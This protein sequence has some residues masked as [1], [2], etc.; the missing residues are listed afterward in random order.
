[1]P[2]SSDLSEVLE[3]TEPERSTLRP[4]LISRSDTIAASL[5]LCGS[6]AP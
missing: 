5:L 2:T 1:M 3:T 4:I 6:P